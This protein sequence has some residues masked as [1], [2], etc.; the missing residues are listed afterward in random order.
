MKH[1][2]KKTGSWMRRNTLCIVGSVAVT[3]FMGLTLNG[4]F[5]AAV[6]CGFVGVGAF[7]IDSHIN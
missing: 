2:T 7:Y 4:H 5:A 6:V 3:A 1:L